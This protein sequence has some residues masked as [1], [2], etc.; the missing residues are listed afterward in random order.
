MR[1]YTTQEQ[2]DKLNELNIHPLVFSKYSIGDL[3]EMLPKI[4][5]NIDGNN[6]LNIFFA[7]GYWHIIYI[8]HHSNYELKRESDKELADALYK[9]VVNLKDD[10]IL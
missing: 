4:I 6:Y 5:K 1:K 3:I 8:N 7:R 2:T 10:S 9:M